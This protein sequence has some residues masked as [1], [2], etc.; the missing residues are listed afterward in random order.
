VLSEFAFEDV[1]VSAEGG[2]PGLRE[3]LVA[4]ARKAPLV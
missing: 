4:R 2:P 1:R 3:M